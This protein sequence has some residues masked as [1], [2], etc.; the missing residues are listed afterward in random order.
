MA[1]KKKKT[2]R[3]RS[4][5]L[6][7]RVRLLV[8]Y[9]V[10]GVIFLSL[11]VWLTWPLSKFINSA[12]IS[13]PDFTDGPFFIWNL[14]WVKK[15]ILNL[16]NPFFSDFVYFPSRSNLALH[17]LTFTSGI[18]YLPLSLF[19]RPLT[20]LNIIQLLSFIA[21]GLGIVLFSSY[22][23]KPKSILEYLS[24][25]PGAIIF[26]FSPF[27]FSHLLAGHYNLSMIW[28][29]P[30]VAYFLIRTLDEKKYTPAIGLGIFASALAYLDLQLIFFAGIVCLPIF[31]SHM[32]F[33]WREFFTKQ[34][35]LSLALAVLV[36][37][38]IFALPYG[39][40][41]SEFWGTKDAFSTYNNGD[42]KILFGFN[43]LNPL[44]KYQ[45]Y[46]LLLSL[47]GSYRE[48]TISIGFTGLFVTLGGFALFARQHW[49]Q[50]FIYFFVL[51][52]GIALSLGPNLQ[53]NNH[54]YEHIRLPYYYLQNLPFFNLGLVP[55]RFILIAY[56]A[57]A[58]LVSL[59]MF[60]VV[61]FFQ[62]KKLFIP[63]ICLL[64]IVPMFI[65]VENYSG[66]MMIDPLYD[67]KQVQEIAREE[68]DFTIL[69]YEAGQRDAYI[70][71]LHQKKV[72]TGFLGRRIHDYY[73]SKY[74]SVYPINKFSR[75]LA[76]ELNQS[77]T[78]QSVV[79][80]FSEYKIRY[81]VIEKN[82]KDDQ[83]LA[84]LRSYLKNIQADLTYESSQ[85]MIYKVN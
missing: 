47:I 74:G 79:S 49:K 75:G 2:T 28:P 26:A 39:Y 16:S 54:V 38:I 37:A 81:I 51:I 77:D 68:G 61:R 59:S 67:I 53:Y 33:K 55:S 25:V 63:A 80:V 11:A 52:V 83:E 44:F 64:V 3:Q 18:I 12:I 71:V 7:P 48:N 66:K 72:V 6:T 5:L 30:F 34:S 62:N 10:I 19:F 35:V 14:W 57:L 17:T 46:K 22:L 31:F 24:L 29:I 1:K 4:P 56:F 15:A 50:K 76:D 13:Q 41:M 45:N 82:F 85:V 40:L 23:T 43:P 78:K 32:I 65:L 69:P 42:I 20:S 73:M 60:S 21:S 36:F 70:Q 27:V 58:V 8:I 9:A 84:K